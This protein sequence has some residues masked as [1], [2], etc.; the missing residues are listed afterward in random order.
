MTSKKDSGLIEYNVYKHSEGILAEQIIL[1]GKSKF[2]QIIGSKPIIN[3]KIELALS[4]G[5]VLHPRDKNK[6]SSRINQFRFQSEEEIQ[7]YI[8]DAKIL[9]IDD[10]YFKCKSFWKQLVVANDDEINLLSAD[11]IFTFFQDKFATTHYV[12]LIGPTG[13]GKNAIFPNQRLDYK[14]SGQFH[15]YFI[16]FHFIFQNI[17]DVLS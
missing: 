15:F 17:P 13:S 16:L 10:L 8:E 2:L 4:Q 1:D 11:T 12:T 3:D 6:T 14:V 5:I 7:R 9:T